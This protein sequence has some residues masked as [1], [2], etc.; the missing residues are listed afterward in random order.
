MKNQYIY[1]VA[2][3]LIVLG[4]TIFSLGAT[5]VSQQ[6]SSIEA[7]KVETQEAKKTVSDSGKETLG[8]G[9]VESQASKSNSGNSCTTRCHSK[10]R[11]KR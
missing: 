1:L 4:L 9:K 8:A 10:P 7:T 3:L 2:V 6:N 11:G 5:N